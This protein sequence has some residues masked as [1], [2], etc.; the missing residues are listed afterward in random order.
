M[1]DRHGS[2]DYK[3][4]GLRSSP[5]TVISRNQRRD[6]VDTHA[7]RISNPHIS[8]HVQERRT[9]HGHRRAPLLTPRRQARRV[10]GRTRTSSAMMII[11][12]LRGTDASERELGAAITWTQRGDAKDANDE[13]R[14]RRWASGGSVDAGQRV[15]E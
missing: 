11:T 12:H 14:R 2:D 8:V 13:R 1:G 5:P 7:T 10:E 6:R 3:T 15:H 9:V 4:E